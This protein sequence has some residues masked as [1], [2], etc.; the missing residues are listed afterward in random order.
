MNLTRRQITFGS[1]TQD[2]TAQKTGSF[3]RSCRKKRL[4]LL[5]S[6]PT[7]STSEK[8]TWDWQEKQ[9]PLRDVGTTLLMF[10]LV[11]FCTRFY[12]IRPSNDQVQLIFFFANLAN[13]SSR[14]SNSLAKR[15][16]ELTR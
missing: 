3:A 8:V 5:G 15:F 12:K 11:N 7:A 10:N 4:A 13:M 16:N 14:F 9:C 1:G 6:F 2:S